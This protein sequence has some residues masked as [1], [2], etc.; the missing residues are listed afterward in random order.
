V[1]LLRRAQDPSPSS[2]IDLR[3]R[4]AHSDAAVR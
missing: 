4:R 2:R 3:H 1:D